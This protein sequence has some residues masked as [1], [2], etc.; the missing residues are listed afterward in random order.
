VVPPIDPARV[1]ELKR[2]INSGI[3]EANPQQIAEKMIEIDALLPSQ[4]RNG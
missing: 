4:S 3:Y 1:A 2:L